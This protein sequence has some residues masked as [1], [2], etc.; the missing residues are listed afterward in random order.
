MALII[1]IFLQKKSQLISFVP[2]FCKVRKA[3][4][5]HSQGFTHRKQENFLAGKI[6]RSVQTDVSERLRRNI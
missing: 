3:G 5:L 2:I 1:K 6:F 4:T